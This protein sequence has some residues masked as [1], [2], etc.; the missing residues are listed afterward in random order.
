ML[1]DFSRLKPAGTVYTTSLNILPQGWDLGFPGITNRDEWFALDYTGRFWIEKPGEY[2]FELTSDDGSR[3]YI[4]EKLVINN[5]EQHPPKTLR[6]RIDLGC[7]IHNIRVSYFQG[8]R[9][10]IALILKV[11]GGGRKWRVFS[12]EEF[13]PPPNPEEWKCE[14]LD[15]LDPTF[16]AR[17][18]LERAA[19]FE[20]EA[21]AALDAGSAF[22][23]RAAAFD[24]RDSP[25]A[26]AIE[27]PAA[28]LTAKPLPDGRMQ[29]AHLSLLSLIRNA[30]GQIVDR[31]S[32]DAPY[33]VPTEGLP[34]LRA[35]AIRHT[36]LARLAPGR[37]T[38]QTVALDREGKR[39]SARVLEVDIPEPRKGIHLSSVMLV[40]R[41][42]PPE[43]ADPE[44]PQVVEGK[45]AVPLLAPE[46]TPGAQP[47]AFFVVYP[48]Q[49]N[50]EAPSIEVE[51]LVGGELL[52]KLSAGLPQPGKSGA[53]PMMVAAATMPG[54]CELRITAVQG[55]ARVT[56]SVAY[57]VAAR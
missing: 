47:S 13:K 55:G 33:D 21:L 22:E 7:G 32:H 40:E 44:D 30:E 37:Y 17:R 42:E 43:R 49:A 19:P 26:I 52:A 1:P 57:S 38:V 54:R 27:I 28:A 16:A 24:F 36:H 15:V 56:R 8:P 29:S 53:I 34:S 50:P 11:S 2:Q 9:F 4:D 45:R 35:G 10:Q 6:E 31:F 48:D 3:L 23:I 12:T 46:V 41:V 39:S 25:A 14:S 51:F 5:D 20:A 18:R